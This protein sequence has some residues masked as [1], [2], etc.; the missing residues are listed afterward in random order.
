M[1]TT[2][3]AAQTVAVEF[4]EAS[5]IFLKND[6]LPKLL[7][8]LEAMTDEQIWWR[9]NEQSNSAGNLVIHLCGNLRQW[10]VAGLGNSKFLRDRDAEFATRDLVSKAQLIADIRA[11][12]DE[13]E[14]VLKSFPASRLLDR[15]PV[16]TYQV[17]ALQSVYHVVEH[18]SYHLGQILYIYKLQ[19]ADDPG[20]YRHLTGRKF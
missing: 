1:E 11:A 19:T 7:H 18:F 20:F 15:V 12:V 14:A 17:S 10:I 9:P 13:V 5:S 3:G 8:C 4:I 6:F 16:Q 2:S